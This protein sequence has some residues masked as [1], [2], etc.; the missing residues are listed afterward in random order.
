MNQISRFAALILSCLLSVA[1]FGAANTSSTVKVGH[2][3]DIRIARTVSI[4][5]TV[6]TPGMYIIQHRV[7][8]TEHFLH[9]QKSQLD[10]Y[11]VGNGYPQ[12]DLMDVANVKCKM[13]KAPGTIS[14]TKLITKTRDGNTSVLELAIEGENVVH[15][16]Q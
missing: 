3:A 12:Y 7:E 14:Q 13:E 4:G 9:I 8:G 5:G 16:I 6:L 2:E 10:P 1:A 11:I 15:I